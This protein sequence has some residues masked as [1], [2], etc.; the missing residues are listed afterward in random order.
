LGLELRDRHRA[1]GDAE[2][3][4]RIFLALVPRLEALGI[5]TLAE[6][7]RACRGLTADLDRQAGAGREPPVTDPGEAVPGTID[8]YPYRHRVA[9]VM[10]SPPVVV[11]PETTLRQAVDVMVARAVSSVF[12]ASPARPGFSADLYAIFTE[13]DAMRRIADRGAAALDEPVGSIGSRP[14]VTIRENAFLYRAVGRMT[15]IGSRHLGVR[16][17]S[18]N[19]VGAVSARD[20]LKLRGGPAIALDDA[21]EEAR[22]AKD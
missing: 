9:D 20:L 17:D 12:V 18:G 13:R 5:R 16:S 22:S 7:E 14:V 2:A 8:S 19:L 11:A 1:S 21:I 4:G 10:T 3:A 15:R 6:A